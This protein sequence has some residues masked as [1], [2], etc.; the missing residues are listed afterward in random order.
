MLLAAHRPRTIAKGS[1]AAVDASNDKNTVIALR[2]TAKKVISANDM[3][4][5]YIASLLKSMSRNGRDSGVAAAFRSTLLAPDDLSL[6][7]QI[8]VID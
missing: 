7:P 6:D 5:G 1:A 8:D 3:R 4:E 2:E